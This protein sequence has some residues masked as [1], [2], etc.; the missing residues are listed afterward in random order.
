MT[1]LSGEELKREQERMLQ[2]YEI[3][4]K[5]YSKMIIDVYLGK[6]D[7]ENC[8]GCKYVMACNRIQKQLE[9]GEIR[10]NIDI[11]LVDPNIKNLIEYRSSVAG[12]GPTL[13]G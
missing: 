5:C 2:D 1:D 13:A 3:N 9:L 6:Y 10:V 4:P 7:A 8:C 11:E 12:E